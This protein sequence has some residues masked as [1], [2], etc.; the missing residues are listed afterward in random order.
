LTFYTFLI[1]FGHVVFV[2][3]LTRRLLECTYSGSPCILGKTSFYPQGVDRTTWIQVK[4]FILWLEAAI[5]KQS[6]LN[7]IVTS[8]ATNCECIFF[9]SM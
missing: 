4:R 2:K 8:K 5:S 1:H 7:Y 6:S 3:N 9:Q